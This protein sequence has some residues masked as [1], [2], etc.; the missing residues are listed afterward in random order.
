LACACVMPC[1]D[2][3][4]ARLRAGFVWEMRWLAAAFTQRER[5]PVLPGSRDAV[6]RHSRGC[7]SRAILIESRFMSGASHIS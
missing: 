2:C 5:V 1:A 4:V 7:Q 3:R 6:A